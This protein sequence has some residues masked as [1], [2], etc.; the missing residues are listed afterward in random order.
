MRPLSFVIALILAAP[1]FAADPAGRW[2][3]RANGTTLMLFQVD[4]AST[5]WKAV[6]QSPEQADIEDGNFSH[7]SGPVIRRVSRAVREVANGLEL[8]FDDPAPG[9]TPDVF[10]LHARDAK[11][12]EVS[13]VGLGPEPVS[14]DR[15]LA[16]EALGNW[17]PNRTYVR[18]MERPTDPEMTAIF[19]A[20]QAAREHWETANLVAM[21]AADRLRRVRVQTLLDAGQLRSGDDCQT[22]SKVDPLWACKIDPRG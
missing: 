1:A 18:G 11:T 4:R 7:V 6:W 9:A 20:D 14:L 19:D 10:I 22:A 12:A 16:T 3:L 2:A 21:S 5:G 13:S 17:D 8:T 15:A